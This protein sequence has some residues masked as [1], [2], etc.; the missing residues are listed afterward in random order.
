MRKFYVLCFM[1]IVG[2]FT[3]F[4]A[5]PSLS[6]K[7]YGTVEKFDSKNYYLRGE[8]TLFKVSRAKL[9]KDIDKK[10]QKNN[11]KAKLYII[12]ALA[13]VERIPKKKLFKD[14]GSRSIF[15][16]LK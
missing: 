4:Q 12:P 8:R 11:K 2:Y 15:K 1:I 10:L 14:S 16:W 3:P 9:R 7:I 5:F 13:I 6:M